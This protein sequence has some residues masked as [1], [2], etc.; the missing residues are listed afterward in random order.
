MEIVISKIR[1]KTILNNKLLFKFDFDQ[2]IRTRIIKQRIKNWNPLI[3]NPERLAKGRR[4]IRNN[5][6]F[7]KL[8]NPLK[9]FPI[10][11][12]NKSNGRIRSKIP[13]Y[14]IMVTGKTIK[15]LLRRK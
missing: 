12:S 7:V 10:G 3:H 4:S 15:R 13:E 14:M 8:I 5:I 1:L 2:K 9:N 11:M 6:S